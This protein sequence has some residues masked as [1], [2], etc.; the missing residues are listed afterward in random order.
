[1]L[2]D[3]D[4]SV[5]ST[6]KLYRDIFKALASPLFIFPRIQSNSLT[7]CNYE[8][9]PHEIERNSLWFNFPAAVP[10]HT[11]T[12]IIP[13]YIH[14]KVQR[15]ARAKRA[16]TI[17]ERTRVMNSGL[18]G[19]CRS[20]AI[21]EL[22]R[23][24]WWRKK[25]DRLELIAV[26]YSQSTESNND[27]RRMHASACSRLLLPPPIEFDHCKIRDNNI[28]PAI[29]ARNFHEKRLKT[30]DTPG[31]NT[32][33]THLLSLRNRNVSSCYYYY[34]CTTF[35]CCNTIYLIIFTNNKKETK[36][37]PSQKKYG[38][39]WRRRR[40]SVRMFAILKDFFYNICPLVTLPDYFRRTEERERDP[41]RT[42]T[43]RPLYF[44]FIW[45]L[46]SPI[47]RRTTPN[48][49]HSQWH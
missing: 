38:E 14:Y 17:D 10:V 26:Q 24:W 37:F 7:R 33:N 49:R 29:H 30:S 5:F 39:L 13:H 45:C 21:C 47:L 16:R 18:W 25:R 1:M 41:G 15:E 40:K 28:D 22:A 42:L 3:P 34:C 11:H 35:V 19:L 6:E 20:T 36:I 43:R 32:A 46:L 27:N 44:L 31:F 4:N 48:G 23:V 2:F 12:V 9:N 8:Y